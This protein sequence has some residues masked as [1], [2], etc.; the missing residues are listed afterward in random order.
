MPARGGRGSGIFL[1]VSKGAPTAGCVGLPTN[2]LLTAL[3]WI[4]SGTRIIMGPD[5]EIR[6]L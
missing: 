2:E 3:R 4:D 6:K 1:H 5:S